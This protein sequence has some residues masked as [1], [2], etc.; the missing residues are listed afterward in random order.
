MS[1]IKKILSIFFFDKAKNKEILSL[2][3]VQE[4][5]YDSQVL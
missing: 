2:K 4:F 3:D 1:N 5:L